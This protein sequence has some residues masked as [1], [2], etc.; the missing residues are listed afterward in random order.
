MSTVV[1]RHAYSRAARGPWMVRLILL[2][3]GR[4]GVRVSGRGVSGI[5]RN[6]QEMSQR[7]MVLPREGV[8]KLHRSTCT[9]WPVAVLIVALVSA[10][11]APSTPT[12]PTPPPAPSTPTP[13]PSPPSLPVDPA[14]VVFSRRRQRRRFSRRIQSSGAI[15]YQIV[16][17][18][19]SA[20]RCGAVPD[21]AKRRTYTADIHDLGG[22]L[23]RETLRR[24][25]FEGRPKDRLRVLGLPIAA[26]RSL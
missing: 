22:R 7:T 21:Y 3:T 25:V 18:S 20:Q 19:G 6:C 17:G 13:P 16:S 23:R 14:N 12:T 26:G 8:V 1:S 10:C 11:N 15:R 4:A 2:P 9:S 5:R 24:H